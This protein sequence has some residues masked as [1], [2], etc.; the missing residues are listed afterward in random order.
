MNVD[1]YTQPVEAVI[2]QER[3]FVFPVP[4]K[5]ESYRELFNEWLRVNPKAAH[6]IELTALAIHRRGL[7][8]STKYLIERVRYESAYRLVAVP[9]TD[10][11]GITHHYSIN[12]TVTPLLAHRDAQI[13]VRQEGRKEMMTNTKKAKE[14]ITDTFA[15]LDCVGADV[16]IVNADTGETIK[17][18]STALFAGLQAGLVLA[19]AIIEEPKLTEQRQMAAVTGSIKQAGAIYL[20]RKDSKHDEVAARVAAMHAEA[21]GCEDA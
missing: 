17:L 11:H 4:L 8:V 3:A 13:H 19:A 15:L 10:Q 2:A 1:D 14:R 5:A 6:E 16:P 18:D 21:E 12:N 7:R 20:R 9:Y